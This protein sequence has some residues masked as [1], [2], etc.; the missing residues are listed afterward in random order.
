MRPKRKIEP[1]PIAPPPP[2]KQPSKEEIRAQKQN[3]K[4][5]VHQLKVRLMPIMDM[6][7]QKYKRFR[8]PFIPFERLLQLNTEPENEEVVVSDIRPEPDVR[9]VKDDEGVDMILDV[10]KNKKFYNLDLEIIEER[11]FNGYYIKPS[12]FLEDITHLAMDCHTSGERQAILLGSEMRSNT[13][14]A[15]FD[16]EKE[17]PNL[18][19]QWHGA[20]IRAEERRKRK[21]ATRNTITSSNDTTRVFENNQT[22]GDPN[23]PP[24]AVVKR[25]FNLGTPNTAWQQGQMQMMPPLIEE[26]DSASN[27][28]IASSEMGQVGSKDSDG[29]ALMSDNPA[30]GR[31][32][33]GDSDQSSTFKTAAQSQVP[34]T[35]AAALAPPPPV[36]TTQVSTLINKSAVNTQTQMSGTGRYSSAAIGISSTQTQF[37]QNTVDASTTTSGKRTSEENSHSHRLSDQSGLSNGAAQET[38]PARPFPYG[39]SDAA[40]ISSTTRNQLL[41][42]QSANTG[43]DFPIAFGDSQLPDTQRKFLIYNVTVRIHR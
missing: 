6:L 31:A 42:Q 14:I 8:R 37:E 16:L 7:K 13:E 1:L 20:W 9:M 24:N 30:S 25:V 32:Q 36:L 5:Y 35:S 17:N 22:P 10:S 3:D 33:H 2:P 28:Y 4:Y 21:E 11:V 19:E 39:W 41:Q 29:D 34:T 38:P 40:T 18:V 27:G 23:I 15:V 43:L 12:Q 26:G